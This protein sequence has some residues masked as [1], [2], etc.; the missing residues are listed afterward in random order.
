M[1][2]ATRGRHNRRC[3]AAARDSASATPER[4]G[5]SDAPTRRN[6]NPRR[7]V[8]GV[9]TG[10]IQNRRYSVRS[11]GKRVSRNRGLVT[12]DMVFGHTHLSMI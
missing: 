2:I 11:N 8:Q 10:W 6:L 3:Q 12:S 5:L 1:L 9:E 7:L 4:S